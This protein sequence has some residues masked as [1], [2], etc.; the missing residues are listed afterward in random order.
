VH[1]MTSRSKPSTMPAHRPISSEEMSRIWTLFPTTNYRTS[2][3]YLWIEQA[4][5]HPS[6]PPVVDETYRA[7]PIGPGD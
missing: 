1:G 3:V 7:A 4:S 6:P 2:V 5:S